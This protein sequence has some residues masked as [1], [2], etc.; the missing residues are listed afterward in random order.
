[1]NPHAGLVGP[2]APPMSEIVADPPDPSCYLLFSGPGIEEFQSV[3][4]DPSWPR[5]HAIRAGVSPREAPATRGA[6]RAAFPSQAARAR[7]CGPAT[8]RGGVVESD[9]P[10]AASVAVSRWSTLEASQ[11]RSVVVAHGRGCPAGAA[12]G[13]AAVARFGAS[14]EWRVALRSARPTNC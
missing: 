4:P 12:C 5:A 9:R 2:G 11:D 13:L 8:E 14:H 3:D 7:S 1:M 6:G 10:Q